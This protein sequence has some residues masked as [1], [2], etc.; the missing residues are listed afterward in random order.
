MVAAFSVIG[1]SGAAAIA[2]N[3]H[4]RFASTG[5]I[6]VRLATPATESERPRVEDTMARLAKMHSALTP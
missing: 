1:A 2:L 4:D 6:A 3:V 5:T